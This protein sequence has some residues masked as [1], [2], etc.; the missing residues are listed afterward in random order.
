MYPPIILWMPEEYFIIN[1]LLGVS[2]LVLFIFR[3]A[4]EKE[5]SSNIYLKFAIVFTALITISLLVNQSYSLINVNIAVKYITP[6]IV[7]AYAHQFLKYHFFV[8]FFKFY[9]WLFLGIWLFR[10]IQFE[11][12]FFSI[13]TIRDQVWWGKPVLFGFLYAAFYFGNTLTSPYFMGRKKVYKYIFLTPLFLIG[14]RSLFL[15]ASICFLVFLLSDLGI[16]QKKIKQL[17]IVGLTVTLF[18]S[19]VIFEYIKNNPI[20]KFILG[21]ERSLKRESEELTLNTFSSGRT[22]VWGV[23][24]ANTSFEQVVF[25]FGGI[26]DKAGVSL[27]NDFFEMFFYYGFLS[28]IVFLIFFYKVYL[29]NAWRSVNY[30]FLAFYAFVQIQMFFNPFTSTISAIYFLLIVVWFNKDYYKI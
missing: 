15:G 21:S 23:Y 18:F 22:D 13:M 19:L 27:H 14:G 5:I 12:P 8:K 28:F 1:R 6:L 20:L 30:I 3:M 11:L 29:V 16:R 9:F 17:F 10:F 24:L 7:A 25:G 26:Y 4:F 2:L